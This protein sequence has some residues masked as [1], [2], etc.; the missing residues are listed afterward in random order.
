MSSKS[1][2]YGIVTG[3]II[4]GAIALLSTPKSGNEVQQ[5][6]TNN[7]NELVDSL[8][9]FKEKTRHLKNQVTTLTK[10][11]ASTIKIVSV[12]LQNSIK[13]WRKDV[14]PTI[15]DIQKSIQE[16][17]QTID[18]LEAEIKRPLLK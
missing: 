10:E 15:T 8:A 3:S 5:I 18:Q 14:E 2:F 9:T 16:L 6:I 4:S 17:H 13:E 1:L 11:S 12:D 7:V